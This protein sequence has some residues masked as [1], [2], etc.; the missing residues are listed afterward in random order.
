M[1]TSRLLDLRR[2]R[3][4]A[5]DLALDC[6]TFLSGGDAVLVAF[7]DFLGNPADD[8]GGI[9]FAVKLCDKLLLE[10]FDV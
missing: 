6:R 1:K 9:L 3:L 7:Q 2:N 4:A 5:F 10:L 8:G